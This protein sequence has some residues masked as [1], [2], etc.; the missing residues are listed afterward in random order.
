MFPA[1]ALKLLSY[2]QQQV[3]QTRFAVFSV[4]LVFELRIESAHLLNIKMTT[5]ARAMRTRKV[6]MKNQLAAV[7]RAKRK[8]KYKSAL[9]LLPRMLNGR[10]L[11]GAP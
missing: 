11:V 10:V 4:A 9:L 8:T 2:R 1:L 7:L 3:R 6:E 5:K